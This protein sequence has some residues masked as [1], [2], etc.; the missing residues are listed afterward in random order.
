[1]RHVR[2][3]FA[4]AATLSVVTGG[5]SACETFDSAPDAPDGGAM[6]GPLDSFSPIEDAPSAGDATID[7]PPP[8]ECEVLV[9]QPFT[10]AEAPVVALAADGA[11]LYW[12]TSV[13]TT[14]AA[15][16]DAATPEPVFRNFG[17]CTHVVVGDFVASRF[18]SGAL[19]VK[20]KIDLD[21]DASIPNISGGATTGIDP[22][23]ATTFFGRT[24]ANT[25]SCPSTV[26]SCSEAVDRPN[27][28]HVMNSAAGGFDFMA[29]YGTT[30]GVFNCASNCG[31]DE[32][33]VLLATASDNLSTKIANDAMFV[34]FLDRSAGKV[35]RVPRGGGLASDLITGLTEPVD[36]AIDAMDRLV[37]AT[38]T[39]GVFRAPKSGCAAP[40]TASSVETIGGFA[41]LGTTVWYAEGPT[42][43]RVAP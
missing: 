25:Y 27:I 9:G 37:I 23:T 15:I 18:Q 11:H 36:F 2:G 1:V 35:R 30:S 29:P 20:P 28:S 24:M 26:T 14:R 10:M 16:A 34:Y 19:R 39:S 6:D 38:L 7:G 43:K 31:V 42:L 40:K 13:G 22:R 5:M 8:G 41:V 4:L 21:T 12:C 3:A 17:A 32:A 33:G